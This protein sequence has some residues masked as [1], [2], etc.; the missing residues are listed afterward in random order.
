MKLLNSQTIAMIG[1]LNVKRDRNYLDFLQN[2][3]SD[4]TVVRSSSVA[5]GGGR[6]GATA[7]PIG[8]STK[9]QNGKKHHVFSTF[10]TALC[11]GV[12]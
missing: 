7:P 8:M 6:G 12:D 2:R 4:Y 10:E 11:S 3:H 5:R 9:V 1:Q